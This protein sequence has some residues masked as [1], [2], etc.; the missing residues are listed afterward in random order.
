MHWVE[1][2]EPSTACSAWE[3]EGKLLYLS[4]RGL[5]R[6]RACVGLEVRGGLVNQEQKRPVQIWV[7]I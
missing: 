7:E 4:S 3:V 1:E 5:R 2:G 6:A